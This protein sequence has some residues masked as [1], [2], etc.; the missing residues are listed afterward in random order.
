MAKTISLRFKDTPEDQAR[1]R[2]IVE[3]LRGN[4]IPDI[5]TAY[6]SA[7]DACWMCELCA[8]TVPCSDGDPLPDGWRMGHTPQGPGP[9]CKACCDEEDREDSSNDISAHD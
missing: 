8:T 6:N 9:I 3:L 2:E 4:V 1:A 7:C 5:T